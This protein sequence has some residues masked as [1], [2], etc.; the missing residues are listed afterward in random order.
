MIEKDDIDNLFDKVK[1]VEMKLETLTSTTLVKSEEER[2]NY[3]SVI[4]KLKN[5]YE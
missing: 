1:E 2:Q 5:K 4:A 3:Y